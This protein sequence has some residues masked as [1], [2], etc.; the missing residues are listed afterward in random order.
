MISEKYCPS[1][2]EPVVHDL[3]LCHLV[4]E[5]RWKEILQTW[6]EFIDATRDHIEHAA[7]EKQRIEEQK[8]KHQT[9]RKRRKEKW[10]K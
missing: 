10:E 4:Q 5:E 8:R 3:E 6:N 7:A 9:W 2:G 1:C